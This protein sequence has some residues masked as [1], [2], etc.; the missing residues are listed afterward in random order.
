MLHEPRLT[1]LAQPRPSRVNLASKVFWL[2]AAV[3]RIAVKQRMFYTRI[4]FFKILVNF[5]VLLELH[6]LVHLFLSFIRE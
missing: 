3:L 6:S 5:V 1:W 4:F 2:E